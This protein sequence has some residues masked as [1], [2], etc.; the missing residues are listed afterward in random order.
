ME[1]GVNHKYISPLKVCTYSRVMEEKGI[2]DA[3]QAIKNVNETLGQNVFILDVYGPI[4][5]GYKETFEQL[6]VTC[7]EHM[8]YCGVVSF[9]DSTDILKQYFLLLFPTYYHG[10]GFAGTILDALAA[11]LPVVA[12]DWHY[13]AEIVTD[14]VGYVYPTHDQKR[15]EELL[16]EIADHPGDI[17]AKKRKCLDKAMLYTE[18][19]ITKTLIRLLETN[20]R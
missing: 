14:E 16:R 19:T 2:S 13:N 17:L 20:T 5:D 1:G 7:Q 8:R 18:E 10:E 4:D 11:G 9:G 12:S 6:C 3:I 15:F